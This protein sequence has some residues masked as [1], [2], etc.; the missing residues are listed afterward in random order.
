MFQKLNKEVASFLLLCSETGKT[1]R[2]LF[3]ALQGIT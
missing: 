1:N 3:I 2:S